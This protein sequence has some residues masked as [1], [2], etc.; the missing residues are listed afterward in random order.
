MMD[1]RGMRIIVD[2]N[3]AK[4]DVVRRSW[5]ERLLGRPWRPWVATKKVP[6]DEPPPYYEDRIAGV[7]YTTSRGYDALIK[8]TKA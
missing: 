2:D 5:G 4:H 3:L 6:R 7:I 8:E 1:F